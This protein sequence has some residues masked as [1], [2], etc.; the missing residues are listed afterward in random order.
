MDLPHFASF[1]VLT[2]ANGK[3]IIRDYL[4]DY[5]KIARKRK[6]GFVL[7]SSTWRASMDWGYKLGFTRNSLYEVNSMAIAQLE[8]IRNEA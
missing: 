6:M 3:E 7:E 2:R 8:D 1:D 4:L 5:I